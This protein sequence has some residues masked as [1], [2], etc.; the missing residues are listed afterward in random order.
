MSAIVRSLLVNIGFQV[1]RNQQIQ[2]NRTITGV[3]AGLFALGGTVS[4]LA[5][6]IFTFIN[7]LAKGTLDARDLSQALGVSLQDLLAMQRAAK[8]FRINESQFQGALNKINVL[9]RDFQNGGRALRELSQELQINLDPKGNALD[10]FN[11]IIRELGRVENEQDRIAMFGKIFG[12][13]IA[14]SLSNLSQ[15]LDQYQDSV[16]GFQE[17]AK[18][19][20]D[21]IKD[22]EAWERG[23]T[24]INDAF[25]GLATVLSTYFLPA[26]AAVV[27]SF[28]IYFQF[29]NGLIK[30][31]TGLFS[32]EGT[33]LDRVKNLGSSIY[34][35]S[36]SLNYDSPLL[37]PFTS[38]NSMAPVI[39]NEINIDV[40]L[41]T[42]QQQASYMSQEVQNAVEYTVQQQFMQIQNNYPLVEF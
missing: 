9:F 38:S 24:Q 8:E 32:G 36:P 6:Q 21:S 30:G 28:K 40:P 42:T 10:I 3:R 11:E 33:F 29:L 18:I 25:R 12:Q 27:D 4:N 22:L 1:N 35:A 2:A 7:E 5:G 41:G 37:R 34:N 19:Q 23:V 15:N 17:A 14:V 20:A 39:N 16:N 13:E 26:V 31:I